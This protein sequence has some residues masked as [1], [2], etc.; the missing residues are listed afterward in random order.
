MELADS[1]MRDMTYTHPTSLDS[2][3]TQRTL[4]SS[5]VVVP[6]YEYVIAVYNEDLTWDK[7]IADHTHVYDKSSGKVRKDLEFF[8]WQ[9]SNVGRESHT[10]LY[11]NIIENYDRLADVTV[12]LQGAINDHRRWVYSNVSIY[13]C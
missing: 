11:H 8:E 1:I 12:F 3:H 9:N 7:N 2:L 13:L 6:E 4:N 5:S 10:Y